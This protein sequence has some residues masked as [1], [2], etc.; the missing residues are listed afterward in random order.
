M[1]ENKIHKTKYSR[2]GE[3]FT[4]TVKR[5]TD[6]VNRIPLKGTAFPNTKILPALRVPNNDLTKLI[7]EK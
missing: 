4:D 1:M 2:H 7:K 6:T 3:T 5:I